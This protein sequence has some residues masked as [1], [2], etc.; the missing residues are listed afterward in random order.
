MQCTERRLQVKGGTTLAVRM[1]GDDSVAGTG[2]K[3]LC[4]HGNVPA[5][6]EE[7]RRSGERRA[8]VTAELAETM[9]SSEPPS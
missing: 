8:R 3:W 2:E 9:Y 5:V 6:G 4:L 1:W 7:G